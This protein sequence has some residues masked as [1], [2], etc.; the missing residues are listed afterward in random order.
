MNGWMVRK[1]RRWAFWDNDS[2]CLTH[3]LSLPFFLARARS[4]QAHRPSF[5]AG[6]GSVR[7]GVEEVSLYPLRYL[8]HLLGARSRGRG[9][10]GEGMSSK[11]TYL[12]FSSTMGGG[13]SSSLASAISRHAWCPGITLPALLD[14]G[15]GHGSYGTRAL[16][17]GQLRRERKSCNAIARGPSPHQGPAAPAWHGGEVDRGLTDRLHIQCG[18]VGGTGD[19]REDL[20]VARLP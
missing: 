13:P 7:F 14:V 19:E 15:G 20:L 17:P 8:V 4:E 6:F 2:M 16:L 9:G 1:P 5:A 10:D 3:H 12:T 18:C 11:H